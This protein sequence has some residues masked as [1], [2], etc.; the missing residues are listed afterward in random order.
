MLSYLRWYNT[1]KNEQMF[2]IFDKKLAVVGLSK[3]EFMT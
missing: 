2:A 3:V 1:I